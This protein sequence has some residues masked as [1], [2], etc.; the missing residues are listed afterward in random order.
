MLTKMLVATALVMGVAGAP[1]APAAQA[2][3]PAEVVR[4]ADGPVRGVLAA[5]HRTFQGIPYAA[6]PVGDLR[7]SSPQPVTPWT[8]VR[9][10]TAPS[11]RCAQ[12]AGAGTPSVNED[13]LYLNVTTPDTPGRKPVM[14][15]VHG[16]GN[17]YGAGG[18]VDPA[19]LAV[20]GDVVVVTVN[21]RLG[22]FGSFAHPGLAGGGAFGMEDQQA[23][24]RWVRR[25]A[26]AFGGDP[27][28][29]TLF[30][31]SSGAWDV[32]GQLT[33]P[34]ARTLFQRVI[35][36]SGT[37][38]S[39]WPA[40]GVIH[41]QPAG[42]PWLPIA[43]ARALGADLAARHGCADVECLRGLPAADLI[44]QDNSTSLTPMAYGT[45]V[46][47]IRPD[48]ALAGG[49]FNRVPVLAGHTRDEGRLAAAFVPR[50]FTEETYQSLLVEAFGDRAAQVA[51][52]YP[53]AA[54]DSP[55]LAYAQVLTDRVWAC[56]HV[57]DNRAMARHTTVYGYEFADRTAPVG[58]FPFPPDLPSGAFHSSE[59]PYL[60]D[61]AGFPGTLDPAQSALAD[62]MIAY[63]SRFA[64]TGNPN[65]G[66]LP[67]WQAFQG[68]NAQSLAP[69]AIAQVD[70]AAEHNCAFWR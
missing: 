9:E 3:P 41:T 13:C 43:E 62:Q 50:P 17:N 36:Q 70:V 7:W 2:A 60:F 1:P 33:S 35:I 14:V 54:F 66:D 23:A 8:G 11:D 61:Q 48:R 56:G 22:V 6:P 53:S 27:N 20:R 55:S 44:P 21:Y 65:G 24:L 10:T 49:A 58:W 12:A 37:C 4:T 39:T 57:V 31:E 30:G 52:E 28:R 15:W 32:C 51:A 59:L 16:G 19:R 45:E 46:L 5:D 67:P 34:G 29:V 47:P 64:A 42:S 63:W 68:G 26:T 25:N 69:G 18:D 40:N 38:A